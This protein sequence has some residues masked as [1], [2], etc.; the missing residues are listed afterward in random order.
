M[1]HGQ[2]AGKFFSKEEKDRLKKATI[3]AESRTIGEIRVMVIDES[4]RYLEAEVIGGILLGGLVSLVA[5]ELFFSG[6]LWFYIPL[7]FL[8]FFLFR[9]LLRGVPGLKRVFVGK[10]RL[11]RAV[12]ERALRAFYEEGLYKTKEQSGVLFF[13]SLL[14]RKVW[15][16]A[17]KGIHTRIHQSTLN[18][19][20]GIVSKG[21][22]E[23]RA[24]DALIEAIHGV[25]EV[26]AQH[27]PANGCNVDELS[28]EVICGTPGAGD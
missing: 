14:E 2:R 17:D 6:S 21:I 11:Q 22:P 12:K 10:A 16:L 19:F 18:K 1:T 3:E 24:C 28:D 15:V 13:L 27:Y 20:A 23:G 9:F 25:G 4:S 26:L 7:T 5:T 8:L